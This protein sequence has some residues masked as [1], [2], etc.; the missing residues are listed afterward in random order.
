VATW[1]IERGIRRVVL[2]GSIVVAVIAGW[3]AH[4]DLPAPP[5][6]F[7]ADVATV[8]KAPPLKPGEV[9]TD[10][11]LLRLLN[12]PNGFDERAC[13]WVRRAMTVT[14]WSFGAGAVVWAAF[15]FFRWIVMGFRGAER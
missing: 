14:G 13:S 7:C 15:F 4:V 8:R 5:A 10:P 6:Q 3:L 9:V 2:A 12:D 1:T 11:A